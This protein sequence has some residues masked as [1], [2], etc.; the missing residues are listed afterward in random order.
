VLLPLENCWKSFFGCAAFACSK[1][2]IYLGN[3]SKQKV[4]KGLGGAGPIRFFL[5]AK[6]YECFSDTLVSGSNSFY[7]NELVSLDLIT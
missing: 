1:W 6:W 5:S 4:V 3:C 2:E 7:Q